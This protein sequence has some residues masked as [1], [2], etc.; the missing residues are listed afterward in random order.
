MSEEPDRVRALAIGGDA[1]VVAL[2]CAGFKAV[3]AEERDRL[4]Q[5]VEARPSEGG[6][7]QG[8]RA[9]RGDPDQAFQVARDLVA[10]KGKVVAD[11]RGG[12]FVELHS[13]SS[14]Q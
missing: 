1:V 7:R 6:A 12:L 5:S 8:V 10:V 9:D 4:V 14:N 13:G 2:A 3:F 11:A